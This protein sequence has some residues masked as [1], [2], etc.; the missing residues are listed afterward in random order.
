MMSLLLLAAEFLKII[1]IL[2]AIAILI[3]PPGRVNYL[4]LFIAPF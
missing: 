2:L 3:K 1:M 4:T